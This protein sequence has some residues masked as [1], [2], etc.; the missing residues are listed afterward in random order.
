MV[1]KK[2]VDGVEQNLTSEESTEYNNIQPLS[3]KLLQQAQNKK[4]YELENSR[5][6]YQNSNITYNNNVYKMSEN[7]QRN[8]IEHVGN[9]TG[10]VSWVLLDNITKVT[11]TR[12]EADDLMSLIFV[13]RSDAYSHWAL[14]NNDINNAV[15]IAAVNL[16][17]WTLI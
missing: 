13:K 4:Y 12:I 14:K 5:R 6:V 8:F 1:L 9:T 17:Q 7:D 11:L 3:S 16:I 2:I 15:D 10:T